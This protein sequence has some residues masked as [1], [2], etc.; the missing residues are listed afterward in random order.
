MSDTEK[1]L[2]EALAKIA[3]TANA[4]M[5]AAGSEAPP[6]EPKD[7]HNGHAHDY[8]DEPAT[9]DGSAAPVLSCVPK[10]LP[11]RLLVKAADAAIRINP[12]NSPGFGPLGVVAAGLDL[13]PMRIAV[14]VAKYWGPQPRRMTVSF[15]ETTPADLRAR[16]VTHLNAWSRTA[17]ITFVETRGTGN[18]RI[19]RGGGGYWSYLGTDI[20]LI[21]Q[22]RPT[23][24]LQAFTMNTSEA[25]FRRVVRHEAGHTLGFPHEHMRQALVARVDKT[26]AYDYFRRTQGWDRATV[27]Q[28]V[29]TS[30]DERSLMGTPADQTSIMCYQLPGSIT[31]DGRPILGG[32]DINSTDFAFAGRI[33]PKAGRDLGPEF[34]QEPEQAEQDAGGPRDDWPESEDVEVD[35][36]L[37]A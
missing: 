33:Y 15:L 28:Q 14:L 8:G 31:R 30:L 21:P 22:N 17:S 13:N 35:E 29:L 26:K 19:S 18:V 27:D 10:T 9:E 4:A 3:K 36:T 25:E 20:L 11:T 6:A 34:Q 2:R 32:L 24:N 23:M 1:R 12:V 5:R 37:G 16:I 7:D